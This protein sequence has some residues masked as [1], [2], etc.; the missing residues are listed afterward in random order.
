MR[1]LSRYELYTYVRDL[2]DNDEEGR[3]LI[4]NFLGDLLDDFRMVLD[5]NI[6]ILKDIETYFLYDSQLT[7]SLSKENIIDIFGE[8]YRNLNTNSLIN[9]DDYTNALG[10]FAKANDE[11]YI[12]NKLINFLNKITDRFIKQV[13]FYKIF[14]YDLEEDKYKILN[15]KVAEHR[16]FLS[17]A[18]K[19]HLYAFCLFIYMYFN[20]I[21]LYVDFLFC[22]EL[23]DGVDIKNNLYNQLSLSSQL[24][25]LRSVNSELN[26]RGSANIRGWCSWELGTF[27]TYKSTNKDS[28]FY[29]NLYEPKGKRKKN[30]QLDGIKPLVDVDKGKLK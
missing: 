11:Y 26:I 7:N 9:E 8:N 3:I 2:I 27:Y 21:F 17:Y 14:P 29:L 5:V 24:L 23:N 25:F 4:A 10:D 18:F 30:R 15:N 19:D 22:G 16:V 6:I 13:G 12:F 1:E 20:G 28:K